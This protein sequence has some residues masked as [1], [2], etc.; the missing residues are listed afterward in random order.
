MASGPRVLSFLHFRIRCMMTKWI[1]SVRLWPTNQMCTI[2]L[3]LQ[4]AW[5]D[6]CR[7]SRF[8]HCSG[9]E[10]CEVS[11]AGAAR[12]SSVQETRWSDCRRAIGR[13]ET[14]E[15]P[16][17]LILIPPLPC[18]SRLETAVASSADRTLGIIMGDNQ[19]ATAAPVARKRG[20]IG[21]RTCQAI[22][23]ARASLPEMLSQLVTELGTGAQYWAA[24]RRRRTMGRASYPTL[25]AGDLQRSCQKAP[26]DTPPAGATIACSAVLAVL[27]RT[28]FPATVDF[29]ALAGA[30]E[31]AGS[32]LRE[33]YA[34]LITTGEP[35][36]RPPPLNA[37]AASTDSRLPAKRLGFR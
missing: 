22:R 6:S 1:A 14:T 11:V 13:P 17:A 4:R 3:Q 29:N 16:I 26:K 32:D 5:R 27:P 9:A 24:H 37:R 20:E 35:D 2:L 23:P 7:G 10:L 31:C 34:G 36:R 33:A 28:N 21:R 8:N 19:A 18:M 25:D 30:T 15:G 12:R